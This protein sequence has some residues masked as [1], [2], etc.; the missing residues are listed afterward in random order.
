ME[1]I[2]IYYFIII[3]ITVIII[4]ILINLFILKFYSFLLLSLQASTPELKQEAEE[5]TMDAA[6]L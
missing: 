1:F 2:F 4:M 3:I 5:K 6:V